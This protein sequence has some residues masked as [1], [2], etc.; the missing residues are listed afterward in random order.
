LN[1][2]ASPADVEVFAITQSGTLIGSSSFTI[3]PGSNTAKLLR[4]LVPQTQTRA[5]DGGLIFVQSSLPI[6]GIELFF[7]R[8]L[9]ILANVPAIDGSAYTPPAR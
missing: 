6:Y 5:S 7:S 4:E 1:T 9:Q 2:N 3:P 8:N